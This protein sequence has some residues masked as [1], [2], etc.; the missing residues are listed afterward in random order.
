[1]KCNLLKLHAMDAL[2]KSKGEHCMSLNSFC[3]AVMGL[4][5]VKGF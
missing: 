4:L 1:M 3:P 5:V 2:S